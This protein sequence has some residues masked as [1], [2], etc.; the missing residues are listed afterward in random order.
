[1]LSLLILIL[2][3]SVSAQD[4]TGPLPSWNDGP[5]RR[6]VVDFVRR[7]TTEG[8]ADYVP[9]AERV[10]TFDNDGT[11]WCEQPVV[12]LAFASM[13]LKQMMPGHPEW[14]QRPAIQA[15]LKGDVGYFEREGEQALAEVLAVTHT[16]MTQEQFQQAAAEFFRTA[17]HPKYG[18]LYKDLAYQPMVEL[19]AFLREHGFKTWICSGG[20]AEFMRAISQEIYGI[21]PEQVIGSMG[22]FELQER[23]GRAVLV[24]TPKLLLNNDKE[25]KPVGIALQ[26]GRTPVLATGNVRSGGDIAMLRFSQ[27]NLRSSLQLLINHDD[28]AREFAY[29]E[30]D[31]ASLNAAK[32]YGWV[33]VSVKKDWKRVFAFQK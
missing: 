24:K 32:K 6:A 8:S 25:N 22:G 11:L 23:D 14:N 16:G 5:V 9:P 21:P 18:V 30:K 13:R 29:A 20:G 17:K 10:A 3:A 2:A 7:V 15:A 12:Q 26:I 31:N 19:L 1:M 33:I 27:S 28:D 4:A